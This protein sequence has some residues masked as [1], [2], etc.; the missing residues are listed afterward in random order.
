LLNLIS[1][2]LYYQSLN[3]FIFVILVTILYG[4][5]FTQFLPYIETIAIK[6]FNQEEYGK[7]RLYG[8]IGFICTTLLVPLYEDVYLF[9]M[10]IILV[11]SII[12]YLSIIFLHFFLKKEIIVNTMLKIEKFSIFKLWPFWLSIFLMQFSF[13]GFYNFFTIYTIEHHISLDMISYIWTF[14]VICEII[15]L[16]YQK[17]ILK[18]FSL[19]NILQFC[20][21]SAT[22]RWLI[23]FLFPSNLTALFLSQIL[24]AFSFAL[25]H[26]AS[27]FYLFD[28][29][30]DKKL[31]QH[32]YL[33]I[34]FGLGSFLGATFAGF[35]Y[36]EYIFLYEALFTFIAFLLYCKPFQVRFAKFF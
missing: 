5:S 25:F 20:L 34:S 1:C 6:Y 2:L 22:V 15:M 14:G 28:K 19:L 32:F 24:H 23:I 9:A 29:Y 7:I 8:S 11:S 21:L 30:E 13:S 10:H 4:I 3:S 33:G 18:K 12:M 31:A 36:G 26:S 35:I 16:Y 17:H 27:I